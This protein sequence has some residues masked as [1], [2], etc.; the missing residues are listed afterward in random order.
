MGIL[1]DSYKASH[2]LQYP[3]C[4]EMVA[5]C[6]ALRAY[7]VSPSRVPR[8]LPF[9]S[10][11][12][13]LCCLELGLMA[14][15]M[16][17]FAVAFDRDTEDTRMVVYGIRYLLETYLLRQWTVRDVEMAAKFYRSVL[18]TIVRRSVEIAAIEGDN[19]LKGQCPVHF[20]WSS[21]CKY[22]E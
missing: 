20:R 12:A 11:A 18:A 21:V 16:G 13:G 17:S 7:A 3:A 1:T 15:S 10:M 22:T 19:Y 14:R 2:Y 9:S 8:V 6:T 5:V 4:R